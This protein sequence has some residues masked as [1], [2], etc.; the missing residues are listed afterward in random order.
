[1]RNMAML[2][3]LEHGAAM[4]PGSKGSPWRSWPLR[5]KRCSLTKTLE[6]LIEKDTQE[7]SVEKSAVRVAELLE[8]DQCSF[9]KSVPQFS[10]KR[11]SKVP[12]RQTKVQE[13]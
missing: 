11:I 6:G 13:D 12:S 2:A 7:I 4:K 1:M 5:L 3:L 8:G 10:S 9:V